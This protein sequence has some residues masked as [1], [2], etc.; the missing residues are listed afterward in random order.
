ML[1]MLMMML[2]F[3]ARTLNRVPQSHPMRRNFLLSTVVLA[4]VV[5]LLARPATAVGRI[6]MPRVQNEAAAA[7]NVVVANRAVGNNGDQKNFARPP[8]QTTRRAV[9][10]E[11]GALIVQQQAILDRQEA[12]RK[13]QQ[14]AAVK[15]A[16]KRLGAWQNTCVCGGV[17]I[18]DVLCFVIAHFDRT[19]AR[20]YTH[21]NAQ[22]RWQQCSTSR[23]RLQ[24]SSRPRNVATAA[25]RAV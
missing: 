24:S 6:Q 9:A 5:L 25:T 18:F 22:Q 1:M 11:D 3:V 23:G 13:S 19:R 10:D 12:Y 4:L 20:A 8:P 15:P 21:T 17:V 16:D 2:L 14:R 7:A